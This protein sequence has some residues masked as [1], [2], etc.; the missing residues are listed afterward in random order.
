SLLSSAIWLTMLSST[1]PMLTGSWLSSTEVLS[2]LG[3][4]ELLGPVADVGREREQ[5]TEVLP[6]VM[7]APDQVEPTVQE[8]GDARLRHSAVK[9]PGGGYSDGRRHRSGGSHGGRRVGP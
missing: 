4:Q 7:A 9:A 8:D 3:A 5:R 2:S 1:A 6:V